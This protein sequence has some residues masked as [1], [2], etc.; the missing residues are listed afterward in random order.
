MEEEQYIVRL[1]ISKLPTETNNQHALLIAEALLNICGLFQ[2]WDEPQH[3]HR[4]FYVRM[5]PQ[6]VP[7]AGIYWINVDLPIMPSTPWLE[8]KEAPAK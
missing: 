1:D 7:Q 3:G 4:I 5:L 8:Y 2:I 6:D